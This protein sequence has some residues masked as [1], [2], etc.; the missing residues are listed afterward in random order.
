MPLIAAF[1]VLAGAL[2][3]AF[4][5]GRGFQLLIPK[6]F[7]MSNSASQLI[8][9][10]APVATLVA[11]QAQTIADLRA[12]LAAID[13]SVSDDLAADEAA[14]ADVTVKAKALLLVGAPVGGTTEADVAA[15]LAAAAARA[16]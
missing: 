14:I 7:E 11:A 1:C 6:E 4:T 2:T 8:A 16:A 10:F 3:L 5:A 9:A 12:Q 13:P 15:Q